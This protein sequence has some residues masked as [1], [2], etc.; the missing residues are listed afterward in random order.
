M[1]ELPKIPQNNKFKTYCNSLRC[2]LCGAQLDGNIHPKGAS[3]YCV[4][5]NDEYTIKLNPNF[6]KPIN[7]TL[8][9]IFN[10]YEYLISIT[11]VFDSWRSIILRVSTDIH[12][13]MRYRYWEEIFRFEGR[14]TFFRKKLNKEEFIRKLKIYNVFS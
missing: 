1:E 8:K 5:D 4:N 14:I 3:L 7:E 10:D 13:E 6:D 9:H 12:P 2:P 11:R